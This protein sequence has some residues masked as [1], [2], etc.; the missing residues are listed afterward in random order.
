MA[1]KGLIDSGGP[2]GNPNPLV[3]LSQHFA[4]DQAKKDAFRKPTNGKIF[5]IIVI[6]EK[7]SY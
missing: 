5:N 2:C 3:K 1:F 7:Y 4:K 6:W